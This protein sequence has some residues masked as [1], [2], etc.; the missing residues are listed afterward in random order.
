[1]S[2]GRC[3]PRTSC[4]RRPSTLPALAVDRGNRR[5]ARN[6]RHR[7]SRPRVGIGRPPSLFCSTRS[8]AK[9]L[10]TVSLIDARSPA[11]RTVTNVTSASPIISAAAVTAVRPGLRTAFSRASRP[12]DAAQRSIG[13]PITDA[14]GGTS[15]ELSS[16]TPTKTRIA[17]TAIR[18]STAPAPL[19]P[20]NRPSEQSATP[21]TVTHDRATAVARRPCRRRRRRPAR[22]AASGG[23]R[24]A[25]RAGTRPATTVTIV[26]TSSETMIVRVS[27]TVPGRRQ[28]DARTP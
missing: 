21:S 9:L 10:S 13:Q 16:A 11:A 7:T 26:P 27:T 28:V 8:P 5:D 20:P 2:A 22:S 6:P 23:T 24:V 15:R 17:P 25:R 12:V 1:M 14:I 18:P 3:P 19:A 4:R